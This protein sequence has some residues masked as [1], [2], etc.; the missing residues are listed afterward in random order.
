MCGNSPTWGGHLRTARNCV[1]PRPPDSQASPCSG[2]RGAARWT[3]RGG[4]ANNSRAVKKC[5]A[6]SARQGRFCACYAQNAPSL[7]SRNSF[8]TQK[9]ATL[10]PSRTT[11]YGLS[12]TVKGCCTTARRRVFKIVIV[13]SLPVLSVRG[14]TSTTQKRS[15]PCRS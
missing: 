2:F 9:Q 8:E 11:L 3:H 1:R 7:T 13:R 12:Q 5:F 10:L 14:A 4:R 15:I 6:E